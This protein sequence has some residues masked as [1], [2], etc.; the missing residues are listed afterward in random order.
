MQKPV[1]EKAEATSPT[2]H[3]PHLRMRCHR[4][5]PHHVPSAAVDGRTV[6][7]AGVA[8]DSLLWAH[9]HWDA[10]VSLAA[11]LV[12]AWG[13]GRKDLSAEAGVAVLEAGGHSRSLE[14]DCHGR[15][16]G[17]GSL[18]AKRAGLADPEMNGMR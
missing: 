2:A 14:E 16:I 12:D 1:E 3:T 7:E 18:S 17:V 4:T 5:G 15:N 6:A 8:R 9:P 13:Q 11:G 10:A